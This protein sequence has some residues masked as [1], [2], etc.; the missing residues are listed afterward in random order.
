M[1]FFIKMF[2]H[3]YRVVSSLFL[4]CIEVRYF[5]KGH[6]FNVIVII[7]VNVYRSKP[8]LGTKEIVKIVLK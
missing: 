5:L 8:H 6:F 3:N 2:S 1:Y 7:I 4:C